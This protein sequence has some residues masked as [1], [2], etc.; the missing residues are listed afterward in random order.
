FVA[1]KAGAVVVICEGLKKDLIS[2]GIS[3]DN[4]TVVPN[5]L[6]P[7]MFELPTAAETKA[8]R[9]RYGLTDAKV[10]G[11][12]GSFFEWEGVDILIKAMAGVLDVLPAARLLLAGGGRHE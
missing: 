8:I 12:F 3:D 4:V 11:F 2:R 10:I 1:R 9:A 7:E 5:A 6:P